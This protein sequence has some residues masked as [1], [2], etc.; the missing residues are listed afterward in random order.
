MPTRA[1]TITVEGSELHLRIGA[2]ADHGIKVNPKRLS[3][4]YYVSDD[5]RE[6]FELWLVDLKDRPLLQPIIRYAVNGLARILADLNYEVPSAFLADIPEKLPWIQIEP[7]HNVLSLDTI[8][9]TTG[10][11]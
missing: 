7:G 2:P 4:S 10:R 1:L 6:S 11:R 8:S 9:T 5:D 3:M